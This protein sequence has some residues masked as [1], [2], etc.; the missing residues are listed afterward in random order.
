M[1]QGD[2]TLEFASVNKSQTYSMVV[3][4]DNRAITHLALLE[5]M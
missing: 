1:E 2:Q 4:K 5:F 3:P